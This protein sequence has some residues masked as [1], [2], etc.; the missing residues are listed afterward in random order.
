MMS[1]AQIS[2]VAAIASSEAARRDV[3]IQWPVAVVINGARYS[4]DRPPL[5]AFIAQGLREEAERAVTVPA[6]CPVCGSKSVGA[7]CGH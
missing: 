6:A 7:T 1:S 4:A 3:Q 5:K 2:V